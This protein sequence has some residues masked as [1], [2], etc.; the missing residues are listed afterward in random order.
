MALSLF[1]GNARAPHV[2]SQPA[3]SQRKFEMSVV[4][5]FT[6]WKRADAADWALFLGDVPQHTARI[7]RC[8][9][10]RRGQCFKNFDS[11]EQK[12]GG[13]SLVGNVRSVEGS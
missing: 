4:G 5:L 12:T 6:P 7:R 8:G 10:T 13:W 2:F 3:M 1:G 9:K 11:E